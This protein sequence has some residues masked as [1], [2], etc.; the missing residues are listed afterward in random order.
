MNIFD[1]H[2]GDFMKFDLKEF[3]EDEEDEPLEQKDFLAEFFAELEDEE[4]SKE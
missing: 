4:N 1:K 3:F 2:S